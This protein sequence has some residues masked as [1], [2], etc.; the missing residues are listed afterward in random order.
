MDYRASEHL[1]PIFDFG[2]LHLELNTALFI[3]VLVL[4]VMF[5]M[6]RLLFQPVLRSLDNRAALMDRLGESARARSEKIGQLTAEYEAQLA[7]VREDVNRY[8]QEAR[9]QA[10]AE[11]AETLAES[12]RIAEQELQSATG[13]LEREVARIRAELMGGVD[14]LAERVTVRVLG[15]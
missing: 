2:V 9:R 3:F 7:Q 13:E 5:A 1:I 10:Q 6:N 4:I 11:V 12:R 15:A 8:R 14:G